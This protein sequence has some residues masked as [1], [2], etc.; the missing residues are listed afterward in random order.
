MSRSL[1]KVL[2]AAGAAVV[3]VAAAGS[4]LLVARFSG[5]RGFPVS[6]LREGVTPANLQITPMFVVRKGSTVIALKP[7][8]PDSTVAVAWCPAQGFFEDPATFSKFDDNGG[9]L[10]GPATR[11]LDRFSSKVVDGVLQVAP[12][13]AA[14]GEARGAEVPSTSLPEC[15]WSHA[16]LARGVSPPPFPSTGPTG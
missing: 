11:G 9:Y 5:A 7:F 10:A 1:P 14:P 6:Q 13:E 16:V 8:A 3:A 4:G 2:I 12:G 15:D